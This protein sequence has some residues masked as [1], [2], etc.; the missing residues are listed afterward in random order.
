MAIQNNAKEVVKI[1]KSKLS[2]EL[3]HDNEERTNLMIAVKSSNDYMARKLRKHFPHSEKDKEDNNLLHFACAAECPG[4]MVNCVF[5]LLQEKDTKGQLHLENMLKEKNKNRETPLHILASN[6]KINLKSEAELMSNILKEHPIRELM[7]ERNMKNETP[8]HIFA[9]T[10]LDVLLRGMIDHHQLKALN[11]LQDHHGNTPLHLSCQFKR[12]EI[13]KLILE[14][15]DRKEVLDF[16]SLENNSGWTPLSIA[17]CSG[18]LDILELLSRYLPD[19]SSLLNKPDFIGMSPIHL[20][21]KFGPVNVFK[22]LLQKGADI[23]KKGPLNKT[24]LDFAIEREQCGII[25]SIINDSR[26]KSVFKI[27]SLSSECKLDTPLRKLIRSFPDLAKLV[28]D[29]CYK[30][31]GEDQMTVTMDFDL[32][33]D[34]YNYRRGNIDF[35][36]KAGQ[37]VCFIHFQKD[38]E[39]NGEIYTTPYSTNFLTNHPLMIMAN[40]G[41]FGLLQHPLCLALVK[42]KWD[43]FSLYYYFDLLFYITFLGLFTLFILTIQGP[44]NDP[45]LFVCENLRFLNSSFYGNET[46][47]TLIPMEYLEQS[48]T[49]MAGMCGVYILCCMRLLTFIIGTQE[50]RIWWRE[51]RKFSLYDLPIEST[52]EVMTYFAAFYVVSDRW[53]FHNL[54]GNEKVWLLI[55]SCA[56]WNISAFAIWLAWI[57]LLVHIRLLHIFGKFS[58]LFGVVVINSLPIIPVFMIIILAFAFGFHILLPDNEVFSSVTRAIGKTMMMFIGEYEYTDDLVYSSKHPVNPEVSTDVLLITFAVIGSIIAYNVLIGLTVDSISKFLEHADMK[59]LTTMLTFALQ[60]EENMFSKINF[61]IRDFGHGK[62]SRGR[63]TKFVKKE[64]MGQNI[65]TNTANILSEEKIWKEI[66]I[67]QMQIKLEAEKE[68]NERNIKEFLREN[69]RNLK[70]FIKETICTELANLKQVCDGENV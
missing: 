41:K 3:C 66:D 60:M 28:L 20:A 50:Y 61:L 4:K 43:K 7:K 1:L 57:N 17:V 27:P 10:G 22:H 52:F 47:D 65:F 21:A 62:T 63:T 25:K 12:L 40:E 56:R 53:S 46:I 2:E 33:E 42:Q 32:L 18:E 36:Q 11:N 23:A 68:E 26:W 29:K 48:D 64:Y 59:R 67:K 31:K 13:T 45:K 35:N 5:G 58:I 14:L 44:L 15:H 38:S 51:I 39:R 55:S 34:T 24:A 6:K 16:L 54:G 37:N 9:K 19:S 70:E 30:L 49:N 8:L 69:E